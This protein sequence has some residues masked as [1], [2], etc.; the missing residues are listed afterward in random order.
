[1][2]FGTDHD[3]GDYVDLVGTPGEPRVSE[4]FSLVWARGRRP[5]NASYR[6]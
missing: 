1:M 6:L 4:G 3:G 5:Q 2:I